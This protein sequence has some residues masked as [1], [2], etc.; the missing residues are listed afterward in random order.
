MLN[1]GGAYPGSSNAQFNMAEIWPFPISTGG[2]T[3]PYALAPAEEDVNA[4]SDPMVIDR[5]VSQ[6]GG[7]GGGRKRKEED[8]SAKGGAGASTSG[9]GLSEDDSKR[10]KTGGQNKI[11]RSKADG[12]G[13]SG[14]QAEQAA[15]AA[16]PPKDYIHVR[17]RRG[18]ATDS[19]S[20]AE[21][22]RREKISERMK[23]LQNLVPGCN[24]VIGK[25]SVLDEIINYVQS[26]QHQ[27]EFLSMKLE[28][29]NSRIPPGIEGL[30]SKDFPPQ[31]F[32]TSGLAFGSQA[33]REYG[34]STSPDW[35]HMQ[36][37]GGFERT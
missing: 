6:S 8:E 34:S 31:I 16:E 1:D 25:A 11:P 5:R 32:D 10:L 21:R 20:L 15:K 13:A 33:T 17:A 28:A 12:E 14:K 29:V 30:P 7:D 27:V 4:M 22:A 35:L 37:G 18:Q 24:K 23:I 19:H 3:S 26:L 36:T 2:A 9:N